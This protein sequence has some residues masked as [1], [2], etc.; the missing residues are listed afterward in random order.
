MAQ[1]GKITIFKIVIRFTLTRLHLRTKKETLYFTDI[2]NNRQPCRELTRLCTFYKKGWNFI[3]TILRYNK[4]IYGR[5]LKWFLCITPFWSINLG[6]YHLTHS[7]PSAHASVRCKILSD[8]P[9]YF[10]ETAWSCNINEKVIFSDFENN[11]RCVPRGSFRAKTTPK[12]P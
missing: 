9:L 4:Q 8:Y 11:S 12:M 6:N 1:T 10:S 3:P 7:H 5:S 2:I